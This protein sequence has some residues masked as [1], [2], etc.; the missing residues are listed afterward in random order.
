MFISILILNKKRIVQF[1]LIFNSIKREMKECFKIN[2]NK[3]DHEK[4]Y[5]NKQNDYYLVINNNNSEEKTSD[6]DVTSFVLDLP[7]FLILSSFLLITVVILMNL[8][9][10]LRDT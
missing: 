6:A 5:D 1:N 9:V 8:L 3:I 2:T 10:L 7:K 4:N